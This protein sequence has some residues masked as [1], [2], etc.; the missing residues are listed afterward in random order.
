MRFSTE[1]AIVSF[2]LF[3]SQ[4]GIG[5]E[6]HHSE[7]LQIN[8]N[9]LRLWHHLTFRLQQNS[10]VVTGIESVYSG[11]AAKRPSQWAT[12]AGVLHLLLIGCRHMRKAKTSRMRHSA[13]GVV[14]QLRFS[15]SVLAACI[16]PRNCDCKY[17]WLAQLLA[18]ESKLGSVVRVHNKCL[19]KQTQKPF[20]GERQ[21]IPNSC[22]A[23]QAHSSQ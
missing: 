8:F 9:R 15:R 1:H 13:A 20:L 5:H 22:Y 18:S 3:T 14:R 23:L 4:T 7:R 21:P 10:A 17:C 2:V 11:S 6:G 12:E 16:K 19:G